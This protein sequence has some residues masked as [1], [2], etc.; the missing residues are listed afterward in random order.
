M[1]E[2]T[3]EASEQQPSCGSNVVGNTVWYQYTPPSNVVLRADTIGSDFNT[4]V[5]AWTGTTLGSLTAIAC[6]DNRA[7]DV[8]SDVAFNATGGTAYLFQVGGFL[9]DFGNLVF[10][11]STGSGFA[12]TVT[13]EGG[14]AP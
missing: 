7:L 6:N 11:L 13:A 14:G 5:A 1:T 9:G 2:A 12:G 4:V 10:N 8:R 3:T